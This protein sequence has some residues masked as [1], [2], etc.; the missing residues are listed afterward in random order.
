MGIDISG[1]MIIG[2]NASKVKSEVYREDDDCE[3]Y[4]VDGNL[5]EEFYEWYESEELET[6]SFHYD[7]DEDSQVLGFTVGDIEPLS[8]KFDEWIAEVKAKSEK[9]KKLTGLEPE[10]IGM[11]NVW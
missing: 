9:F 10:L 5:H 1:G 2:H 11:Q 7:A 6:Y 8:E 4:G 3:M